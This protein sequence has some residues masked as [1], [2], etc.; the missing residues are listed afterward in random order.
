MKYF[1]RILSLIFIENHTMQ[2]YILKSTQ[3]VTVDLQTRM[4]VH[5]PPICVDEH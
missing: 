1:E 5:F 4:D 2:C 3:G